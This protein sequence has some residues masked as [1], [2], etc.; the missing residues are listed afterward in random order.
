MMRK[1]SKFLRERQ[2]Q[3]RSFLIKT[4]EEIKILQEAGH[5]VATAFE[6]IR[7]SIRP[8]ITLKALDEMVEAY[9]RSEGALPLYKGYRGNPP[10][11]PPFPGVICA[12]VNQEICHG[13]PNGR[14]LKEGDIVGIDIGL[15][16]KGYCGDSCVTYVVGNAPEAVQNF[17]KTAE[18]AL[19][20]GIAQAKVGNR[21][22]EIGAAIEGFATKHGYSV[23]REYGGHGLGKELHEPLSVPHHGPAQYGPVLR[24]G[25]VFTIEPMINMG[26]PDCKLM[27]DGWSVE[28]VDGKLSA[29]FEHTITVTNNGPLI[30]SQKKG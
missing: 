25:M 15:R 2:Q 29:Q 26:K 11:H 17:V 1:I 7:E 27:A 13:F 5:I 28:T 30:I 4:S 14:V 24:P 23:V 20:V 19:Y 22:G 18:E 12:S 10:T 9:I 21:L 6:K 8:G 16:Y 3:E